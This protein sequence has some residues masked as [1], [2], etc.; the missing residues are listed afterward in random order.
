MSKINEKKQN[1]PLISKK[2][3]FAINYMIQTSFS[4]NTNNNNFLMKKS[5]EKEK[6]ISNKNKETCFS[7]LNH[8]KESKEGRKTIRKDIKIR[9][10][11][12]QETELIKKI[13]ITKRIQKNSKRW[14][15]KEKMLFLEGLY[16]FGCD[17]KVIKKYIKSR[18][19]IQVRSHAQKFLLKL[20]KFKDDSLGIDF[21]RDSD[22]NSQEIIQKLKEIIDKNK[23]EK[24]FHILTE[25][26]TGKNFKKKKTEDFDY[27]NKL[28]N[29]S[30]SIS[31]NEKIFS[32]NIFNVDNNNDNKK[33]VKETNDNN[34]KK[35]INNSEMNIELNKEYERNTITKDYDINHFFGINS[36]IP[37]SIYLNDFFFNDGI[38]F[39]NNGENSNNNDTLNPEKE[40]NGI[41][42]LS[43]VLE[44]EEIN[45]YWHFT[46]KINLLENEIPLNIDKSFEKFV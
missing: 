28:T 30:D 43:N 25:K 12:N 11:V 22:N 40:N 10:K 9:F 38:Y 13:F 35:E 21:T 7:S 15:K 32:L 36:M 16:K 45:Y 19:S 23:N 5:L 20:R 4:F 24:I 17:W 14:N 34:I 27:N 33:N 18:S 44:K 42:K 3:I 46:D 26:L 41:N 2:K 1:N 31:K 37:N 39:E 6:L 29:Y 8:N